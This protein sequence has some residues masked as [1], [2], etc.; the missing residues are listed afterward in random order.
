MSY[1]SNLKHQTRSASK[2]G[3]NPMSAPTYAYDVFDLTGQPHVLG[4]ETPRT[5][6]PPP[7]L[8]SFTNRV[9]SLVVCRESNEYSRVL[10]EGL[11]QQTLSYC[12]GVRSRDTVAKLGL[13]PL[14]GDGELPPEVKIVPL[15][16]GRAKAMLFAVGNEFYLYAMVSAA[17][18]N[19]MGDNDWTQLLQAVIE[20]LRPRDL[21][22][23]SLSRLVRAFTYSAKVLVAV[24]ENVERVHAGSTLISFVG[25]DRLVGGILWSSL[26]MIATSERDLI[27]QR[28]TSGVVAKYFRKEWVK[29][30]GSVPLGYALDPHTKNLRVDPDQTEAL[31]LVLMALAQ[32]R[33][34]YIRLVHEL[35][36]MGISSTTQRAQ[37]DATVALLHYPQSYV[38]QIKRWL[39]TYESG[40]Y[41]LQMT[42]PF[43][44]ATHIAGLKVRDASDSFA[45][46][47]QFD[48]HWGRPDVPVALVHA[49]RAGL[50]ARRTSPVRGAAAKA[51]PAQLNGTMW[52]QDNLRYWL[53]G[54]TSDRYEIRIASVNDARDNA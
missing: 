6:T 34:D 4:A 38:E 9:T 52:E 27:V 49:A 48:Y 26:S 46:W 39:D 43:P 28:L 45:G 1:G 42:N 18:A 14:T 44:G 31:R 11:V 23:A 24:S 10:M 13:T 22:A 51:R 40:R 3:P 2:K 21:Y 12:D 8:P 32:P 53:R 35:A 54:T 15:T 20:A 36:D 41:S 19:A 47:L 37:K 16:C 5:S 17:K 25:K 50:A 29:G 30:A 33:P 7:L